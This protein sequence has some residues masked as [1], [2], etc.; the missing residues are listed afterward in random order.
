MLGNPNTYSAATSPCHKTAIALKAHVDYFSTQINIEIDTKTIETYHIQCGIGCFFTTLWPK[1]PT[2]FLDFDSHLR[3]F[4]FHVKILYWLCFYCT[5]H[6]KKLIFDT[7][8]MSLALLDQKFCDWSFL[9]KDSQY[10][11]P[12]W[13]MAALEF[14]KHFKLILIILALKTT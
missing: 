11:R 6:P 14:Q 2:I 9:S 7:E 13:K 12:S 5:P 4:T 10:C 8:F 3:F 1:R